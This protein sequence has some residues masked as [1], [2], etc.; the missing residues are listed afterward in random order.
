MDSTAFVRGM[1]LGASLIMAIGA[2]NAFVLR[3][4]LKREHVFLVA[5]FCS[6][7]DA[8]LISLGAGGF[9]TLLHHFPSL[10][11]IAAWAGAL[12]LFFYGARSFYSALRP[13]K[14]EVDSENRPALS[15]KRTLTACL[16]FSLLNPHVYLDT[17][18]L[19]GSL[20]AQYAPAPRVSF[21]IGAMLSS[22]LWFFGLA[23]GASFLTP[24]FRDPRAWR[25]LDTFIGI[26]MWAIAWSLLSH[27]I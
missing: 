5:L 8:I 23:Y 10:T 25:V 2:Q 27:A 4:G 20:A 21:A 6:V 12:F 13:K 19:L 9:G 24:L 17:I 22:F 1:G 26:I 3:Q 11:K 14:L 7:C 18:V 15:V 16:A